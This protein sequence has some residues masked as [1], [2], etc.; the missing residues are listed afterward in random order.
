M[1]NAIKFALWLYNRQTHDEQRTGE[2]IVDNGIGFNKPDALK[3]NAML[4][5]IND[6]VQFDRKSLAKWYSNHLRPRLM[7][8]NKQFLHYYHVHI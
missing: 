6:G 3:L 7:K 5:S 2:T 8:Y 4:S 1:D